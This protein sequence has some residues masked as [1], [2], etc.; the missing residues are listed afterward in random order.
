M[1]RRVGPRDWS[2]RRDADNT[3]CASSG[4]TRDPIQRSW[5]QRPFSTAVKAVCAR[6]DNDW[7]ALMEE[8]VIPSFTRCF[9]AEAASR[10][11]TD[12]AS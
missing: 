6:C 2:P 7:M 1:H 10:T 5:V 11:V 9:T 3:T 8:R 4:R 12:R